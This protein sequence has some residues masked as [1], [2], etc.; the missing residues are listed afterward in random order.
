MSSTNT[1]LEKEAA[2]LRTDKQTLGRELDQMK[3][4]VAQLEKEGD[5][6]RQ[7]VADRT[8]AEQRVEADNAR[9]AELERR[10]V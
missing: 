7:L 3:E 9:A 8:A 10:S 5:V 6:F 1:V 4:R 2:S